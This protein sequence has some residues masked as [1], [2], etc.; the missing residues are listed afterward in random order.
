MRKLGRVEYEDLY[1]R[2]L[3]ILEENLRPDIYF[4]NNTLYFINNPIQ[5][6]NDYALAL[7]ELTS[8]YN[9]TLGSELSTRIWSLVGLIFNSDY[10]EIYQDLMTEFSVESENLTNTLTK[11]MTVIMTQNK[12]LLNQD[13][14]E[15]GH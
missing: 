12:Y 6:Y 3:D 14:N 15:E 4:S 13:E 8:T 9:V 5:F 2:Y 10:Q 11:E 7:Q 1:G